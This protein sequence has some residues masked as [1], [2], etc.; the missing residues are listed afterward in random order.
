MLSPTDRTT[1]AAFVERSESAIE[2][3]FAELVGRSPGYWVNAVN[4][5]FEA[6]NRDRP[7][8]DRDETALAEVARLAQEKCGKAPRLMLTIYTVAVARALLQV[9]QAAKAEDPP[10]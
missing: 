7:F 8:A 9:D 2:R 10:A 3:T 1:L 5:S 6:I 4:A